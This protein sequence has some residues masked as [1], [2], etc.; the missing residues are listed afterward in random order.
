MTGFR[1]TDKHRLYIPSTGRRRFPV[2]Q[3]RIVTTLVLTGCL[4]VAMETTVF[5]RPLWLLRWPF[6]CASPSLGLLFSMAVGFLWGEREGCL[7]GLLAGWLCDAGD[8]D[9]ILLPLLFLLCGYVSG[10]IGRRRLAQNLPSFTVFA[11]LG[12][13]LELL[14]TVARAAL[15]LRALPPMVWVTHELIPVWLLTVLFSPVIYG[16]VYVERKLIMK[17]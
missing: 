16:I 15:A 3:I 10:E 13:G 12:G 11:I 8:A 4:L 5:S 2:E 7:T 14:F 17:T 1:H 6:G 9:I